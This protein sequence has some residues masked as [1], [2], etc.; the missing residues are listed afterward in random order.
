VLG[1]ETGYRVK[2]QVI[3]VQGLE[4]RGKNGEFLVRV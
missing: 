3:R 2:G 1:L 4:F